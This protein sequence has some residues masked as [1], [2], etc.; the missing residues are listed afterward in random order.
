MA[1]HI[2]VDLGASNGRVIVGDVSG[3]EVMNRFVTRNEMHLHESHWDI[4]YIFS[5]IKKGIKEAFSRYGD[6]IVSIGVDSWGVDYGL[7]DAYG[8]LIAL[9][10]HYRD[11]RTDGMV[12]YVCDKLGKREIFER[13][14][15]AFQPFNTLYQLAAMQVSRPETLALAKHYLSIPDL[16]NYWLTGSM[17]NEVTHASTT[18]LYNP[19]TQDWDWE[20]IEG[21]GFPRTM[22]GTL[23]DSGT[24]VGPLHPA[25]AQE[26]HAPD[27]VVVV[28][29]GC[30]DTASAV[31]AVPAEPG[32]DFLYI[33]SGTWSLLGVESDKPI[34]TE[35][36]LESGFTNEVAV[37]KNIRF[38]KNIMGMWIQQ[39]CVRYWESKGEEIAWK[40]LDAETL[41]CADYPGYIDPD[42]NRYLKPNTPQ[43]LMID[44]V[45]E[46][47][48]ELGFRAPESKGEYMVAIYRGLAKAYAKAIKHLESITGKSYA[49]LHII[50]GGCKNEILDQWS[51][52]ETGLTVYAGP[53]EA[54]ALGNILVQ[55][56]ATGTI[57]SLQ[58]GRS[59]IINR[60]KVK[61]FDPRS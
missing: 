31:A 47:T 15:L 4:T 57:S 38:L 9:P 55:S 16:I 52:D 51:A 60:Q 6:E 8:S 48:R 27:S 5:E 33:S 21:M 45:A 26:L 30:H 11:S 40:D 59:H 46:N 24:V 44:R 25:V 61:R 19:N 20:T 1:K 13:T 23:V 42:D 32:K 41:A 17:V 39:E 34:I 18:Q 36:A 22:F 58:E 43:S 3:F 35:T 53:I 14:G 49:N 7:L 2:A 54:T 29:V 10:Y 50:G 56:V 12:E 37:N 28:A